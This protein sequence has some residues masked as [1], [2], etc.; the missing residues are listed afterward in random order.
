MSARLKGRIRQVAALLHDISG[1]ATGHD[2][3]IGLVL[4]G[5]HAYGK[6]RI[7]SDVDLILLTTQPGKYLDNDMLADFAP[8]AKLIRAQ[9]WG[10]VTERRLR[11]TNGLHVELNIAEPNWAAIPLDPGTRQVLARG[12]R[13]LH[14]PHKVLMDACKAVPR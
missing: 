1:W 2:D 11:L 4:V 13:P 8:S 9:R 12:A 3:I 6:P 5:S 14:D 7:G 10:A